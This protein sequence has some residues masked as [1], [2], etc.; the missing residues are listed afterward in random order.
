MDENPDLAE[1][2]T[3]S[4]N[5]Y[6]EH[7]EQ[8]FTPWLARN[9]DLL[10]GDDLLNIPLEVQQTEASVGRYQADIIADDPETDRTIVIE[11]QFGETDHTHLGQSLVYTAGRAADVVVWI[12]E[13]F[14]SEHISVF[15]WLN[16]RTDEE[17]AFFAIE[18]SLKRIEDSPYAPAFTAVERPDEWSNRVR[19]ENLSETER[20]QLQFWTEYADRAREQGMPQLAGS[21]PS[22]GAS[23]TV[24]IGQGGAYIRPTFRFSRNELIAMIRF[25]DEDTNFA[26]INKEQFEHELE[27]AVSKHSPIYF[28]T[29]ITDEIRWDE[30]GEGESYDHI[31]LIRGD[32]DPEQQDEWSEYHDWLLEAAQLYE[33]TI[34]TVLQ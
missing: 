1:L 30:A 11:N 2:Q 25:T 22:G 19:A 5:E 32:V 17:A 8:D 21:T 18:V 9:I 16:G 13:E 27:N 24:R 10:S 33:E 3:V 15:R 28:D 26:G 6:F 20:K 34:S 31:L 14:T 4:I 23:H 29:S 7:E 12:A